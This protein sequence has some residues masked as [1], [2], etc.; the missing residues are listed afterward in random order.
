MQ[1]QGNLTKLRVY[2][3]LL[4]SK[5]LYYKSIKHYRMLLRMLL[6]LYYEEMSFVYRV[7]NPAFEKIDR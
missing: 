7:Y 4:H 6:R 3:I 1:I 5:D 2:F